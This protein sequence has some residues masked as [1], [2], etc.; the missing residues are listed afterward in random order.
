[1]IPSHPTIFG[2][3]SCSAGALA[4]GA[5]SDFSFVISL[6]MPCS[7]SDF[8]SMC[9]FS[10]ELDVVRL[11][12]VTSICHWRSGGVLSVWD[13]DSLEFSL[14]AIIDFETTIGQDTQM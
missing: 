11:S 2:F 5:C 14:E 7:R 12:G 3:F 4:G 10:E 6:G 8:F 1:M 9:V 13:S